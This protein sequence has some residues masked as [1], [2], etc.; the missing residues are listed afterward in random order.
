MKENTVQV[1]DFREDPVP[2]LVMPYF[3]LGNLE[4]LHSESP[5]AVGETMNI[6]AQALNALQYL[7]PRGVAHR[8]LKPEN[9]LVESRS[10]L[11]IKLADF[12]LANDR[13]DL[14]SVCGTQQ[15]TTPEI[16]LGSKYTASVDLWSIGV[17]ILQYMYGLPRAPR[18]RRR[19]HKNS[20]AM[21]EKWGLA[22]CHRVVDHAN[23]WDSDDLIDLLTTGMLRMRLEERLS[24]GACFT[25]GCDLGLLDGHSL[26]SGSV[27][28]T[29]QTAL[30]SGISDDDG[31]T[32][33][34]LDALWDT[35]ESSNHDDNSQTG[36]CTPEQTY[37]VLESRN[38]RISSSPSNENDHDS[39][40]G[41]FATA[42]DH[43]GGNVQSPAD[44]SRPLEAGS[45]HPEAYKRQRSPAVGSAKNSSDKDQIKRRPPEIRLIQVPVSHAVEISDRCLEHDGQSDQFC[46]I[47]DA[48]LALLA[49]LLGIKS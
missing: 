43:L 40:L 2:F 42:L 11:S 25:K 47:Y 17:I 38:L 15:Y 7:H 46:T 19:Q 18:Q 45:I 24:A 12:G 26:G 44:L 1:L 22:W 39:Q 32:T 10:P 13:P 41:S 8:D 49:D 33:I 3:P 29:Q 16:H 28:P 5:I 23:D 37:G 4:D 14:K 48:V 35:K 31:S 30:Q 20:P 34:L 21:L 36:R 6:F 27:T 9:I